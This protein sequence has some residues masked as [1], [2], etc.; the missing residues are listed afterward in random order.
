MHT[1][2]RMRNYVHKMIPPLKQGTAYGMPLRAACGQARK[3]FAN[4][5]V[6]TAAQ[7]RKKEWKGGLLPR[8]T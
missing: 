3:G 7:E 8:L 4:V 2:A 1:I 6:M 5:S